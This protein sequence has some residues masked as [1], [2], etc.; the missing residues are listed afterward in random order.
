MRCVTPYYLSSWATTGRSIRLTLQKCKITCCFWSKLTL[1]WKFEGPAP[2]RGGIPGP[3][4][5][6]HCLCPPQKN[7]APPQQKMCPK[8][9][10]RLGATGIQF[11]AWDSQ[12]TSYYPRIRENPG[13]F[14]DADLFFLFLVFIPEFVEFRAYFE[15]KIFVFW[16][17][18]T[19]LK[20]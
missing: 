9:S 1:E 17:T 20:Q 13:I 2:R 16:S 18:L 15:M 8:E 4:P 10:N 6:N 3:C 11:E 14:R 5:P 12:N 19:N 7:C